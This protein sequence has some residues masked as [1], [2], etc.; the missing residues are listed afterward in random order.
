VRVEGHARI[1]R[2]GQLLLTVR[3]RP[4]PK[5]SGVE[6]AAIRITKA[7]DNLGQSLEQALPAPPGRPGN[8]VGQ[9]PQQVHDPGLVV[10]KCTTPPT[11]LR[12]LSGTITIRQ[13]LE[14]GNRI[15]ALDMPFTLKDVSLP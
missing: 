9:P 14:A 10:L 11:S 4:E 3:I 15:V 13:A 5:L 7:V 1:S 6:L 2:D 12:E 8:L